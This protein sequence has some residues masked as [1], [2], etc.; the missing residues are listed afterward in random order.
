MTRIIPIPVPLRG[1][2]TIDPM[3]DL[4]SGYARELTNYSL[5]NG[6]LSVRPAVITTVT[7]S[8]TDE[9]AWISYDAGVW[10]CIKFDGTIRTVGTNAG[11]GT[12][13]GGVQCPVVKIKHV[14][15]DLIIG[16]QAPRIPTAP[17]TAWAFTTITMTATA[18]TSACSHK[19]RLYVCDGTNI[20]Y[21]NLG[22]TANAMFGK[23]PITNFMDNQLVSRMFSLT[24][25]SGDT[26]QSV[27]VIF[28]EKGKVLV[29]QGDFPGSSSWALSGNYNMPSLGSKRMFLEIDGDIFVGTTQ[30]AYWARY[31]VLGG[32]QTA[33]D[34]SPSKPIENLWQ[35]LDWGQNNANNHEGNISYLD[36]VD[37]TSADGRADLSLDA[38]LVQSHQFIYGSF[39]TL[40]ADY[41]PGNI[42]LV[43]FR[44]Y[45]A[46]TVWFMPYFYGPVI[47]EDPSLPYKIFAIGDGQSVV[48]LKAGLGSDVSSFGGTSIYIETSW[49]TPYLNPFSGRNQKSVGIR[50]TFTCIGNIATPP[51]GY[52]HRAQAIYD[53]SDYNAPFGFYTQPTGTL[54]TPGKASGYSSATIPAN[55][56]GIYNP[57][58]GIG[59]IGSTVSFQMT[60]KQESSV[61]ATESVMQMYGATAYIE[62]GG[63]MV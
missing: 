56:Y 18:I 4:E 10:N 22:Q 42:Y 16:A 2:N 1:L 21:S 34:N 49:K 60:Q 23:F 14:S 5:V 35:A 44:K 19:G 9:L 43:Y 20:E 28:G 17:Y 40:P 47:I 3:I 30:Y 8:T 13:G 48:E 7:Q 11:A 63:D 62:D 39:P 32:S 25:R 41:G 58:I 6:R 12:I 27:L 26:S 50:P 37:Y 57:F 38:I 29:Y 36:A 46:W 45:R 55:N 59:G 31:L 52:F 33:Y 24:L 61:A 54:I 53:F 51:S 15:L